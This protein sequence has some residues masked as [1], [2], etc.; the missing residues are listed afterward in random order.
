MRGE[1]IDNL[2]LAF[3]TPLRAQNNEIRG[4]QD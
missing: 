4:H 2:A 3:I 1:Q